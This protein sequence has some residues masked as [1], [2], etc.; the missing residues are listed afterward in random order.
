MATVNGTTFDT[1]CTPVLSEA[2]EPNGII[3]VAFDVSEKEMASNALIAREAQYRFLFDT[4]ASGVVYQDGDGRIMDANVAAEEILGLT[5]GQMTGRDTFDPRWR[6]VHEDGSDFPGD[7]HPVAVALR[8]GQAV[9]GVTMGIFHPAEERYRWIS[10]SAVPMT[11][12]GET[13]PYQVYA[14]FEDHTEQR[15]ADR[16]LREEEAR[17]R[18]LADHISQLAW[19]TDPTGYI[20]WYNKRWF[21]YTGTTLE[22]VRGLGW[23]KVHHPDTV[24]AVTAKF[25]AH[26]ERGEEWEDT[27]PIRG[28]DGQYRWFLSRAVPLKDDGGKIV[29]WFGTNTD[30]T[31]ARD[32]EAEIRQSEARFRSLITAT[33]QI[34][35]TTDANGAFAAVQPAWES[36]TGQPFGEYQ[37]SGWIKAVHEDDCEATVAQWEAA[38]AA[39]TP[40]EIEHRLRRAD[41]VFRYMLVRAVPVR[42]ADDSVREWVGVHSDISERKTVEIALSEYATKQARVAETLQR[43]L[44]NA[45]PGD[46]FAGVTLATHY[47]PALDEA[48]VGGD[49]FD[50]FALRGGKVAF[51]VGDV[52]GKGLK[53]AEHTGQIKYAL[54]AFLRENAD[55]ADAVARVNRLLTDA[56]FLDVNFDADDMN[57]MAAATVAVLEP[58]TGRLQV[59]GSGSEF[60]LWYH[61]AGACCT[62][63]MTQGVVVGAYGDSVYT[64]TEVVMEPGDL[65]ILCTDGITEARRSRHDFFGN[66]GVRA[67]AE[68]AYAVSGD[69]EDMCAAIVQAAKGYSATGQF[70]D[71]VC[72]LVARRT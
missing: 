44:L 62:E 58:S 45:P 46:A 1:R 33:A 37:Q 6:A 56:Q 24:D 69:P 57:A 41:G 19:M 60:P 63:I 10:V 4:V 16:L 14:Y 47:E 22:T 36:F 67:A 13:V 18:A 59:T 32:A 26:I 40:F 21:D 23:Q 2:G 49:F 34:V 5:V 35:W 65:L 71:D 38:L 48:Q 27:F 42:A 9:R 61:G 39:Q 55:P 17:F 50:V 54:R 3:A 70:S 11:R 68:S 25:A 20:H 15:E 72:L 30:I 66:E 31:A 29:R 12:P 53:A 8:T 51:V 64:T 28:V 43:S 52:T 7:Q